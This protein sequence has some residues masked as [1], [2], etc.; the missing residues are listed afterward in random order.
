M[1]GDH[2]VHLTFMVLDAEC[3]RI[4]RI[5]AES[6]IAVSHSVAITAVTLSFPGD[7]VVILAILREY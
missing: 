2:I 5:E 6:V 7:S 1:R 3:A 4:R